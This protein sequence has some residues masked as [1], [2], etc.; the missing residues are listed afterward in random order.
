MKL[1]ALPVLLLA[2]AP[3][4][5]QAGEEQLKTEGAR[6]AY[7]RQYGNM[8][9]HRAFAQSP[10]TGAWYFSAYEQSR[11]SAAARALAGCNAQVPR[12]GSPCVIVNVNG[13]WKR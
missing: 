12:G 6:D 11:E 9:D 10:D 4:L 5:A 8:L 3:V 2:L 1:K 7:K 13:E